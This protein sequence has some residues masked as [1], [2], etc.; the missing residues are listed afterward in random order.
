MTTSESP[1][2]EVTN[3]DDEDDELEKELNTFIEENES[4]AI[5]KLYVPGSPS[6]TYFISFYH[7][8]QLLAHT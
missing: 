4:K 3:F 6:L 7:V 8:K 2:I 5:I 1:K